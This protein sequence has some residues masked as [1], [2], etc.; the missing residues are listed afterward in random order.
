MRRTR[1]YAKRQ[2]TW[3][4]KEPGIVWLDATLERER[5]V[6]TVLE[7]W[8]RFQEGETGTA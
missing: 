7:L 6:E 2:R 5:L 8:A 1:Q 4:R 3:F